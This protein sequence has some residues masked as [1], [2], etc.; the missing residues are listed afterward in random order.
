MATTTN[1]ERIVKLEQGLENEQEWR[2]EMMVTMREM[3]AKIDSN[4]KWTVGLL[5]TILIAIVASNFLG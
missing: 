3:N 1:E 5:I 2:R 4:H